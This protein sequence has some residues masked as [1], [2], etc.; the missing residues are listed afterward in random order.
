MLPLLEDLPV[1]LILGDADRTLPLAD[2]LRLAALGGSGT[3]HWVVPGADH[4]RA[5]LTLPA[6]YEA[7]VSLFLRRVLRAARA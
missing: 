3:E 7:R 4:S 5:H 2:G 6:D 1:L